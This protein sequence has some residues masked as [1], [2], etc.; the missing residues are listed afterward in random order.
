MHLW[1]KSKVRINSVT[2]NVS[3]YGFFK[4]VN[5]QANE[6]NKKIMINFSLSLGY[7]AK[8]KQYF[9]PLK[10]TP[11]IIIDTFNVIFLSI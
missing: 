4:N 2:W 11:S 9:V 3:M 7:M 8:I 6:K 10:K 1:Y 5:P